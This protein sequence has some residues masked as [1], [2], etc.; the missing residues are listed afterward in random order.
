MQ[1]TAVKNLVVQELKKIVG[2]DFVSTTPADLYIYAQDMTQ[3]EPS[4]P[5]IVVMPKSV[6]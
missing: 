1:K 2:N 3:A 4:W 5:D 6:E